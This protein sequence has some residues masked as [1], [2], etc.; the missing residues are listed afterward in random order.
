MWAS[1]TFSISSGPPEK[2]SHLSL[3]P[4]IHLGLLP[5]PCPW[6]GTVSVKGPTPL[7][8]QES[9]SSPSASCATL[10]SLLGTW[11]KQRGASGKKKHWLGRCHSES[12]FFFFRVN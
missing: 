4:Q 2:L 8:V 1:G 11:E 10:E 9:L 7:V 6:P 3:G 5:R 12:F